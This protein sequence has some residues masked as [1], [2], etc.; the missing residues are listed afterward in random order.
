VEIFF[1]PRG[2]IIAGEREGGCVCIFKGRFPLR[3]C[4]GGRGG[5]PYRRTDLVHDTLDPVACA[6]PNEKFVYI[7]V[8]TF[9]YVPQ[10]R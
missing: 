1:L 4:G 3:Y 7:G 8:R 2:Y 6:R 9:F 10:K 5:L